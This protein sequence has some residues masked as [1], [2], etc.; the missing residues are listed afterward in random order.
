MP[1]AK[2]TQAVVKAATYP[3][4]WKRK[5]RNRTLY[6]W[7]KELRGFGLRVFPSGLK[8]FVI[9]YRHRETKTK[10]F[11][12]IGPCP[13]LGVT[14][15]KE[16]ARKK[17]IE[18]YQGKDPSTERSKTARGMTVT[19][20][21]DLYLERYARP[22]KRSARDDEG[23][24]KNYL[25][26]ALG[27][28]KITEIKR[29]D[30]A[31]LHA[32][33][34]KESVVNANR[35]LP[36]VSMMY[37]MAVT[38]GLLPEAYPNPARG[39]PKLPENKRRRYLSEE[40]AGELLKAADQEED[41]RIPIMIRLYLLLGCR[42]RELLDLQWRNVD[43]EYGRVRFRD[44]K[45]GDELWLRPSP[46]AMDL[47]RK[48]AELREETSP[49]VFPG[50]VAGK[51]LYTI[52]KPW[53]RIRDKANLRDVHLH[54]LRATAATWL[55]QSGTASTAIKAALGHADLAMTDIYTRLSGNDT[56]DP[57]AKLAE[58]VARVEKKAA[59]GNVVRL[60]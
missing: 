13:P 53:V 11:L 54:D 31:T 42:R 30:I 4:P 45:G 14:E 20:L 34:G 55:G 58:I 3:L 17:L 35:L 1:T 40:E 47:F 12:S 43:F 57:L 23:R 25:V 37:K 59:Q 48:L 28:R 10:R 9:T 16:I 19:A 27:S 6:F 24:I 29:S 33:V 36:I 52:Q 22:K 50:G 41:P 2:L 7:D 56:A 44:R 46:A 26:P 38:W 5:N 39:I 18:V 51:P 32:K 49:Y 8:T 60:R 21:G 15:A